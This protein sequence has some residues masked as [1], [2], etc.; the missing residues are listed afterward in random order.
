L[1]KVVIGWMSLV[2]STGEGAMTLPNE[3]MARG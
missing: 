1:R 3:V 2:M